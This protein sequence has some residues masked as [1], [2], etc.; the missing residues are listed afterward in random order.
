[1][2]RTALGMV[3]AAGLAFATVPAWAQLGEEVSPVYIADAPLADEAL[4]TVEAMMARGGQ[5]EAV[6][7]IQRV[8]D[9][10]GDRLTASDRAGVFVPVR[11]RVYRAVLG[12]PDLLAAYRLRQTARAAALLDEGRWR[13]V[14]AGSWLT[15]PGFEASLRLAQTL[16]ES[17]RFGSAVRVLTQLEE[18]PDAAVLAPDAA[19]LAATAAR[20]ADS[21]AGWLLASRWAARAGMAPPDRTA[22]ER[23]D[24]AAASVVMGLDWAGLPAAPVELVGVV[25]KALHRAELTEMEVGDDPDQRVVAGG[26]TRAE[27]PWSIGTLTGSD[28]FVSDGMTVSCLDRFTLRP[29][30]R[31]REPVPSLDEPNTPQARARLGRVVEDSSTV[32]VDGD[33]VFAALGL[34]RSGGE[35]STGRVVCADRATGRVRWS[36]L[37]GDLSPE[38]AGADP[39]GPVVVSGDVVVVGARKNL[40]SRR[41]VGLSLVGLDRQTGALLWSRAVGSAGSLPFQQLTHLAEGGA[42]L[43]G[44]VYWTDKMGLISALDI[45]TGRVLWVRETNAPG[46][47]ARG[48]RTPF[49]TS[50]PIVTEAGLFV[51]TPDQ[52]T[53][54]LIDRETGEIRHSRPAEPAGQAGYL[55]RVGDRIASVGIT[56]AAFYDAVRFETQAATMSGELAARGLRGRAVAAGDRL[57]V[58]TDTGLTLVDPTGTRQP[59]QIELEAT[60]NPVLA[61]GQV[62]I[63]DETEAHSFLSWETAS[64]ML[65]RRMD[66]GEIEAALAMAEL[67]HRSGREDR[68][69]G[70]V[71]AAVKLVGADGGERARVFEV[72]RRLADPDAGDGT[73]VGVGLRGALLDRMG[74]LARSPEQRVTHA[75]A[76]GSWRAASGDVSGAAR[77]YQDLLL[78]AAVSRAVWSGGGLSVR[79]ELEASRRL[80]DLATRFGSRAMELPDRMAAAELAAMAPEADADAWALLARRYPASPIAPAA[81]AR[82]AALSAAGGRAPS[83]ERAARSGLRASELANQRGEVI[84]PT[85]A[86]E[87]AGALITAL[88]G[89][90]R[91]DEARDAWAEMVATH[92]DIA[93]TVDGRA[94]SVGSVSARR[95]AAI[96]PRITPSETP[97]MLPGT[98]VAE[99][100]GN[101]PALLLMHAAQLGEL[102]MYRSDGS[103]VRAVWRM[104]GLGSVAPAVVYTDARSVVLVWPGEIETG[105]QPVAEAR[106]VQTGELLWSSRVRDRLD[107]L[108]ANAD[109]ASRADGQIVSPLD[110]AMPNAQLIA[111]CDGRT[112]VVTDRQGK[113]V[114]LDAT[115]G[116]E[117]WLRTLGLSRVYGIDLNAGVLGVCGAAVRRT[118]PNDIEVR[119]RGVAEAVD[120]RT[121]ETIQ[122]LD[123][124][125]GEA[126]WVR[127]A[128][129][130]QVVVASPSRLVAMD[131]LDARVDW[132]NSDEELATSMGAW[133]L[134]DTLVVLGADGLLWP[135]S[136]R[137]GVR[138]P[139]PMDTLGRAAD[140]GWV[141]LTRTGGLVTCLSAQG[142]SVHTPDGSLVTA[143][144]LDTQRAFVS[145]AIAGRRAVLVERPVAS[146][147]GGTV[148]GVAVLD[149]TTGAL[150]DRVTL[151]LPPGVR[152]SPERTALIDG[153]I[154]IGFGEVSVVLPAPSP[155]G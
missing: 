50:V 5:D 129:D 40:R 90:G 116:R 140:R 94:V 56:H 115:T 53:I 71:D 99:S 29:R 32:S 73:P 109:P 11:D 145:N 85:V 131:T 76:V 17:A 10:Q 63:I 51:L 31:L 125:G 106:S 143:D 95:D 44:V 127:V 150:T 103:G 101:D 148:C 133:M 19:G 130:G 2:R 18:H 100:V 66:Q 132:S 49:A 79:G 28:L 38:L 26:A 108:Q 35:V 155:E 4:N 122:T 81:W 89:Q 57:A 104:S 137:E 24:R 152:R 102:A 72:V 9:E 41:L 15:A 6:R 77:A 128:A 62:V 93:P 80:Q 25:P 123:D 23:P 46:L 13:E 112:L 119:L 30:W 43:D 39:R 111:A 12:Q 147:S 141:E 113:T 144:A 16:T 88:Q 67:A 3:M 110:G 70:A 135:V 47:Y 142:L 68:V 21:E 92:G 7:L 82:A 120:P 60:G 22:A 118:D 14:E 91:V 20:Y 55:V 61:D 107:T 1:M 54:V 48:G 149:A 84:E 153:M 42:V 96:G 98:P 58:P 52:S 124:L 97:A 75:M 36:V 139:A 138:S 65:Q 146:D 34:P 74:T 121:G 83:A 37:L 151:A 154:V 45:A 105:R 27:L 126:R 86:A 87:L 8:L 134:G 69:L 136:R 33:D 114:G 117:L 64:A 78:D 59:V